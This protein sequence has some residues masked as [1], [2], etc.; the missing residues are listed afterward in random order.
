MNVNELRAAVGAAAGSLPVE[1]EWAASAPEGYVELMRKCLSRHTR[2][3]PIADEA[4]RRLQQM[5]APTAA[6][7]QGQVQE[8]RWVVGGETWIKGANG[9]PYKE[10]R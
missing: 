10:R 9:V 2:D 4:V 3:R 7:R 5:Q 8:Q 6:C 1:A